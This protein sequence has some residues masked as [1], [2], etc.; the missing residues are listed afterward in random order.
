VAVAA[1]PVSAL[2]ANDQLDALLRDR[3][4]IEHVYYNHRLGTK[5]SFEQSMPPSLVEKLVREDLHKEAVLKKI[6]GIDIA[7]PMLTAEVQRINTSTRAADILA[8]LKAAL[9]NDTNRF[10]R[11]IAKPIVV[12]R[13]L[14]DKFDN[15]DTL[16]A[17]QRHQAETVRT[18]L[19]AAKQNQ[20]E[21]DKLVALFKHLGSNQVAETTWQLGK[22]PDEKPESDV[23]PKLYFDYLPP[24]LQQVLRVQL[25]QPGDISAVIETPAG[26]QLYLCE[27]NTA[28]TLSAATLTI[29]K[30]SYEQWLAEQ[31]D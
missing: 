30:R 24:E 2:R 8:E 28:I 11:T 12:D 29:P 21:S 19:L 14:R 1:L 27:T 7:P 25:R 16:H 26:F 9:D 22:P 4:A 18:N 10:A 15:D 6:Y 5:S 13:I 20:P 31:A 3:T 17:A 23:K